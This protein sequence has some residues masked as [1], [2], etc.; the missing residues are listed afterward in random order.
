MYT[1]KIE[2][3]IKT[4]SVLHKDQVRKGSAGL[5]Y[6]SH[7]FSVALLVREY[8]DE[9][10]VVAAALLHDTLEDTPYTESELRADFGDQVAEIVLGVTE[11]AQMTHGWKERKEA[12]SQTLRE[13]P[14]G[15]LL[16]SAADKIHNM[17]S[18]LV[19]YKE[20][21]EEFKAQFGGTLEE[22]IM[23]YQEIAD[24]LTKRLDNAILQEFLDV[25]R[26]YK[27]F[28]YGLKAN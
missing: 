27:E 6:I 10:S 12:Y 26:E 25:F 9:E 7:L 18:V 2:N 20:K 28:I 19:E 11:P 22:R 8:T 4:V 16:V 14:Q 24:V 3:A 5:P 23:M 21:P 17:R 1:P 15:S 13:A